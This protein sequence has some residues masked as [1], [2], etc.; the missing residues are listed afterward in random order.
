MTRRGGVGCKL[1]ISEP[2]AG[3]L[4]ASAPV[5]ALESTV[6]AHGLAYPH[7]LETTLEMMDA[8]RREGAVPALVAVLD[9]R[10][11]KG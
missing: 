1:G 8:I 2:V 3:A 11:P 5:V 6:V 9:G 10:I 4:A 7:N